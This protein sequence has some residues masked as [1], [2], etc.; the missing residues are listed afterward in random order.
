MSAVAELSQESLR[1]RHI[2]FCI[3]L[4]YKGELTTG[5][6]CFNIRDKRKHLVSWTFQNITCDHTVM[7]KNDDVLLINRYS[8]REIIHF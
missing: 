5:Y 4:S 2:S 7:Y 8:T 1:T 3:C 6:I